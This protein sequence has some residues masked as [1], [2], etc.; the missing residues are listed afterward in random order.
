M[1][2]EFKVLKGRKLK[3]FL[4]FAGRILPADESDPG[5]GTMETAR[6]ADYG[7]SRMPKVAKL[8]GLFI[9]AFEKLGFFFGGRGFSKLSPKRQERQMRWF[10]NSPLPKFRLGFFGLKTFVWY[11][12]YT[13][14]ANWKEIG[15]DGPV[16]DRPCKDETLRSLLEGGS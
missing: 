8:I 16:V 12:Y 5:A 6:L 15:Y 3:T 11:G 4:A 7:M 14:T 13:R 2:D 10:E 9:G 1:P